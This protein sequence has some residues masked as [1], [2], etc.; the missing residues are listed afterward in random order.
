[1]K[2]TF[3]GESGISDFSQLLGLT[4]PS[5]P[6]CAVSNP[7][8]NKG[9]IATPISYGYIFD[10]VTCEPFGWNGTTAT[11]IITNPNPVGLKYLQT[12]PEPNTAPPA[13]GR[14]EQQTTP[15]PNTTNNKNI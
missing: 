12:F 13:G 6:Q 3:S 1:M 2:G 14:C 11:N 9:T 8:F 15:T 5:V 10:P 7:L 4:T